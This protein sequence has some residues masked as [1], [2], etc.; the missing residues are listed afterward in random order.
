[1]GPFTT[2]A[3]YPTAA[4]TAETMVSRASGITPAAYRKLIAQETVALWVLAPEMVDRVLAALEAGPLSVEAL[5]A[6]AGLGALQAT[7]VAARLA[8]IG[9][10]TLAPGPVSGQQ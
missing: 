1:M 6:A 8:K 5:A 9:V 2:F 3:S 10:V 7:E 4:V